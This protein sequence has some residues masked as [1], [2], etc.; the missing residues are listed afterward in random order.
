MTAVLTTKLADLV[1]S[2]LGVVVTLFVDHPFAAPHTAAS[3][4]NHYRYLVSAKAWNRVVKSSE[5]SN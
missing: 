4:S 3:L 1:I 2:G 5:T